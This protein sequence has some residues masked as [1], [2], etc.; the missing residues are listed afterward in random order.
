MMNFTY[1][2][3]PF[4]KAVL[5]TCAVGTLAACSSD[6]S[7]RMKAPERYDTRLQH[8]IKVTREQVSITIDLPATGTAVSPEDARRLRGFIRD[9]VGR[10][11]TAVMV[12]SQLG[13]RAREVLLAQG[14][15]GSELM[16]VPDTNIKAPA[17]TLTFTANVAQVPNCG[18][19]SEATAFDPTN[20]PVKDFG[21]SNRRNIGLIVA[22]PGDM[23]QSQ[24]MSGHG[25]AR[26]D[27]VLDSY[28]S[29]APITPSATA[30][31]DT[32]AVSGVQ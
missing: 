1:K 11:R 12:E 9:F 18:D 32:Q 20:S 13:A 31:I 28:N 16:M 19:W 25:A 3:S 26:S 15:R 4:L 7:L 5:I 22:D 23:I 21:C 6:A 17:A 8:P 10:G 29:G 2:K 27:T 14:L 24:P 30:P